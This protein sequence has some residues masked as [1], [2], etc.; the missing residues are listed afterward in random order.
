MSYLSSSVVVG[1]SLRQSC[2]RRRQ[3]VISRPSSVVIVVRRPSSSVVV[4]CLAFTPPRPPPGLAPHP[5]V[6]SPIHCRH[7]SK[8]LYWYWC[9]YSCLFWASPCGVGLSLGS[10]CFVHP[11]VVLASCLFFIHKDMFL[12]LTTCLAHARHA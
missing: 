8:L 1:P 12:F 9:L 11:K 4:V 6:Q 3:S 7:I 10:S 5:S 2:V